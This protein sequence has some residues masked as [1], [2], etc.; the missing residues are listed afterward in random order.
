MENV[1][2]KDNSKWSNA[3]GCF[4]KHPFDKD[5]RSECE[6]NAP[7]NLEAQSDLLLAQATLEKQR[8]DEQPS[9]WTATQTAMVAIGSI[10]A[11]TLMVVVIKRMKAKKS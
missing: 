2:V 11:I 10:L 6:A 9:G 7:K 1:S 3:S 8:R 4:I 5:K